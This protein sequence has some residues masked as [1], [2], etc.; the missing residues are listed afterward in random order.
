MSFIEYFKNRFEKELSSDVTI[1]YKHDIAGVNGFDNNLGD[2]F[3]VE[4][5]SNTHAGYIAFWDKG[6]LDFEVITL[7]TIEHVIPT[8]IIRTSDYED[9]AEVL[10]NIIQYFSN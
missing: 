8:K 9:N 2:Y 3:G 10:K 7:D 4:L 5:E 6:F 1:T